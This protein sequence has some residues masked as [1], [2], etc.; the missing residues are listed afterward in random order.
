M[1][2]LPWK[3]ADFHDFKEDIRKTYVISRGERSIPWPMH[4]C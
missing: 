1:L 4:G 2:I 3:I